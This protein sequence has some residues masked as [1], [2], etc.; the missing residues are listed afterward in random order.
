MLTDGDS[1][2]DVNQRLNVVLQVVLVEANDALALAWRDA[3][4]NIFVADVGILVVN[5]EEMTPSVEHNLVIILR[6]DLPVA[7]H[8]R[9][10]CVPLSLWDVDRGRVVICMVRAP[11]LLITNVIRLSEPRSFLLLLDNSHHI[12]PGNAFSIRWEPIAIF[13]E[14]P[15]WIISDVHLSLRSSHSEPVIVT[16]SWD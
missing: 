12:V 13:F 1:E 10:E 11:L 5:N 14:I 16:A 9:R 4:V 7:L 2:A 15:G 6:L 8:A 3:Q